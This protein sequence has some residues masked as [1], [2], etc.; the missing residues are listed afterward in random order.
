MII[1]EFLNDNKIK[2]FQNE[3]LKKHST[4]KIGG[5]ADYMVF[6]SNLDEIV[7][8]VDFLNLNK[9]HFIVTGNGSNLLFSDEG[10]SGVVVNTTACK[11]IKVEGEKIEAL[12]GQSLGSIAS[13]AQKLSLTGLEFAYG[14]PGTCGGAVYMNAGA[15]GGD[16]SSVFDECICYDTS[17]N[18]LVTIDKSGM[19]FS[20]RHS[21]LMDRPTLFVVS[22]TFKLTRGDGEQSLEIMKT[23]MKKRK[24]TQPYSQPSAG[25]VF[26]RPEGYFAGK[27][28]EDCGLKGFSMGGAL[29]SPKHA[30]FIVNTGN[31]T[32]IDVKNLIE[33]IQNEVYKKFGVKLECEIRFIDN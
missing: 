20:Y 31:A 21:V 33:H 12:C 7:R 13:S 19:E 23:N 11:E 8:C 3:P 26:K 6:P 27:L 9:I 4:F 17:E 29:V 14:I 22:A 30:G 25:S 18:K 2:Y 24:A 32:A 10:F 1:T 5:L 15:F 16:I 28:I